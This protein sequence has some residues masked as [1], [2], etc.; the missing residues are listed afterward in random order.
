MLNTQAVS[1]SPLFYIIIH[2][3]LY[4]FSCK[5]Q[6][7][8]VYMHLADLMWREKRFGRLGE[9]EG[10]GV[11]MGRTGVVTLRIICNPI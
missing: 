4:F 8:S 10:E 6:P 9:G 7:K 5:K 3:F 11:V 1:F 2:N